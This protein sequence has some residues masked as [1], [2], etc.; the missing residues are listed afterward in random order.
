MNRSLAF[1]L[2]LASALASSCGYTGGGGGQNRWASP[3]ISFPSFSED[4]DNYS[5]M[6][7]EIARELDSQIV[8]R[9]GIVGNRN[10]YYVAVTV[11]ENLHTM[12]KS[13]AM[14]R[15]M[16]QEIA[17]GLVALGYNVQDMR[18]G[19][20]I[21]FDQKQ[22]ELYLTRNT[23]GLARPDVAATLVVVGTFSPAPGGTRFSIECLDARNN[24]MV[25]M[26]SRTVS[27]GPGSDT[28]FGGEPQNSGLS[29]SVITT[30]GLRPM[31]YKLQ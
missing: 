12:D 21:L 16:A 5:R 28:A 24:N 2:L 6:A 22:G 25:A 14:A 30:R 4:G 23:R 8:P 15:L 11:P 18:K 17:N 26:A 9:M 31:D 13:S 19:R 29:P 20:E 7:R 1:I 27:A 10:A 3:L